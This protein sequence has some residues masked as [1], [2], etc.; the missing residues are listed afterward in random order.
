MPSTFEPNDHRLRAASRENVND[1]RHGETRQ[2]TITPTPAVASVCATSAQTPA[3]DEGEPDGDGGPGQRG[4]EPADGER[5]EGELAL[6]QRGR[7]GGQRGERQADPQHLEHG[8]EVVVAGQRADDRRPDG[9][10]DRERGADAER[11]PERR[12]R[13]RVVQLRPLDEGLAEAAVDEDREERDIDRRER[14]HAEVAR[15]EQPAEDREDDER[16]KPCAPFLQSDPADRA[17]DLAVE[18]VGRRRGRVRASGPLHRDHWVA[19]RR[20]IAPCLPPAR[21]PSPPTRSGSSRAAS[22][23]GA[24]SSCSRTG[25]RRSTACA[26]GSSPTSTPGCRMPASTRWSGR[27]GRWPPS[28]PTWCACSATSS[29]AR[30][31]S[32]ARSRT[33]R[34]WRGWRR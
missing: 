29:T 24:R 23:S 7:D 20:C 13:V 16:R 6:Q 22:S 12:A 4:D 1:G 33:R 11:D 25:R 8:H 14:D 34:S 21:A 30:R 2:R 28:A 15:L 18:V 26:S 32:R 19:D 9:E 31:C 10:D 5:A 27:R 3:P 17:D